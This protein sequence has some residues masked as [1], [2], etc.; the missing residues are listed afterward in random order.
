MTM[1]GQG[2]WRMTEFGDTAQDGTLDPA[3]PVAAD[4]DKVGRPL[5]RGFNDLDGRAA[6][7]HEFHG[8]QFWSA[9]T[10]SRDERLA[11]LLRYHDGF[12]GRHT[13]DLA[14]LAGDIN[15][16]QLRLERTRELYAHVRCMDG[17]RIR[18]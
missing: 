15:E 8:R 2:A 4:H 3:T 7:R 12:R 1:T 18:C 6:D 11:I 5:L 9:L 17:H 14:R 10:D 13:A 16:R